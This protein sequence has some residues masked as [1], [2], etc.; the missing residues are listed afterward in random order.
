VTERAPTFGALVDECLTDPRQRG[1]P[2]VLR[3]L[4]PVTRC[5]R[6]FELVADLHDAVVSHGLPEGSGGSPQDRRRVGDDAVR[7]AAVAVAVEAAMVWL[8]S[9]GWP[10]PPATEGP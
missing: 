10:G 8:A 3:E 4:A 6:L 2:A 7:E 9:M 1:R 5:D